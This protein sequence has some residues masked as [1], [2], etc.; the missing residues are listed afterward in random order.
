MKIEWIGPN[1]PGDF[2]TIVPKATEDG[3]YAEWA[4]TKD[5]S[6]TGVIAQH[7]RRSRNPLH[8]RRRKQG[9]SAHPDQYYCCGKGG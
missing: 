4:Y 6:P 8:E 2:I 3:T 5:G 9:L 7:S 1:N